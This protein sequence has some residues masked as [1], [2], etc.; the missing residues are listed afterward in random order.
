MMSKRRRP[1]APAPSEPS[2]TGGP[3]PT[4]PRLEPLVCGHCGAP[5]PVG[6][7]DTVV[8]SGCGETTP[9]PG[10]YKMMRDAH[11]LS[12]ND[13][14]HLDALCR[15]ISRPPATWERV[16]VWVGYGVGILTLV[17]L[18]IGALVGAIGG[19]IVGDK[20]GAGETVTKIA[21]GVGLV[22]CGVVSIPYVGEASIA[23]LTLDPDAA[24][25]AVATAQMNV[26][27]DLAIAGALYFLGVVPI[28][29]AWRT[30]QTI[31]GLDALQAKLSA[32]PAATPGGAS[33]CRRCGAP[34]DVHPGALATRCIYCSADNLV[35]VPSAYAA[36]RKEDAT[37]INLQVQAAAAA[38]EKTKSGDRRT[39]WALLASG[40]LLA[41]L[42]CAA[43]WLMHKLLA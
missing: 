30:S 38:N 32:Q 35:S 34:L 6:D 19:A 18:A 37:A 22:L 15:D 36:K 33:S 2:S 42:L 24:S 21:A 28:A 3:G 9:V 26:G 39:M 7:G 13:A 27:S 16:A 31:S 43:G 23:W 8:C 25:Q 29:L 4:K 17:V 5:Q 14:A 12:A 20:L 1:R 40:L 41:P 11:R 10:P